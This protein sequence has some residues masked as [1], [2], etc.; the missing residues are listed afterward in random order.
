MTTSADPASAIVAALAGAGT[1][2]VFGMPG[3]GPNL[4]VA[5]AAAAAGLRFV[6]AHGETA[7]TIMAATYADLTGAPGAVLVT[8]GPGLASAV[9]GIA[10]AALDRLPLVV[11]ADTVPSAAT[12]VTHQRI[13]QDALGRSVAKAAI[14]VG[15]PR[16]AAQAVRTALAAPRGPVVANMD[17]GVPDLG[18]RVRGGAE[19]GVSAEVAVGA[20][21]GARVL[22][23]AL[24][25]ARR[26]VIM[27]G[28]GAIPRTEAVSRALA[29]SGIPALHT[30]RA[31]GVM[32]DSAAEA[33]GLVTGGTMEW[34]LLSTADLIVGLGVDEAEMIPAPWDYP[35][36]AILVTEDGGR[37]HGYFTGATTLRM[38]LDEALDVL[39]AGPG[40]D[41]P[42]GAGRAVKQDATRRLAELAVAAPGRLAPQQVVKTVRDGT[43]PETVAT[44]DAGAHMLVAMPLWEVDEPGRLLIS[45]GLATMG[46]A[47]PAAIAAALCAPGV[48]VVAFTG[49][50]GLGMT[51]AELET[52]VRLSLPVI[53]VV[54]NDAA[55]SLIEIKQQPDGQG[56][57]E[58]VRYRPVSYAAAATALGAAGAAVSTGPG[59]AAA[60]AAALRRPGP[61][62]ID[63]AVDPACYPA[64]MDLTRG[65]AGRRSVPTIHAK[66]H[67]Q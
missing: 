50:G 4:D 44:V 31:R 8:R 67:A 21:T 25:A 55:L 14:T 47:L 18:A 16:A 62:V 19:A 27:L 66:E 1:R 56:G 65:Q 6:L 17:G 53:V 39:A 26:P 51:L 40:H 52:A 49:D 2:L 20:G 28:T 64:V 61:T 11:I 3:G 48:P 7:A 10:H 37:D 32:P 34:P 12:R 33:A 36:R 45:S 43:P 5:G 46:Y 59:L 29:G 9:N 57:A 63:A 58:A 23:E 13:D 42:D 15:G 38:P 41:W 22:S 54:F 30:Y 60:L 24:A 35:A